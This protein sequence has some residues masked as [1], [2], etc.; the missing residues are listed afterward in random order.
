VKST[1]NHQRLG[2]LVAKTLVIGREDMPTA[3]D[4]DFEKS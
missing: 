1:D 2:D 3:I 4:F